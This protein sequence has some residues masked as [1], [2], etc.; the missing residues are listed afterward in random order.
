MMIVGLTGSIAMGKTTAANHL[1]SRGIPVFDSDAAVHALYEGEAVE[2][3]EQAF[4]GVVQDGRVDR[5]R[6]GAAIA[7]S[8]EALARLE[9]IVHPMVRA[10]QRDF[11]LAE[12]ARGTRL[13]V[14][15]IPLLYESGA[16]ALVDAV[17]VISAPEEVQ[18]QRL[19]SRRGMTP[20]KISDLLGRQ[21]PDA[22]KRARADF[23][24]DSSGPIPATQAQLDRIIAKLRERE[25]EKIAV[26]REMDVAS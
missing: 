11:L 20:E 16:D 8:P 18:R 23:L 7:G 26:W 25:G 2:R 4:P 24:V 22:E 17:I 9:A 1:K 19:A 21:M 10:K 3:I 12:H 5:Q 15:D 6:L 13:A 14:L